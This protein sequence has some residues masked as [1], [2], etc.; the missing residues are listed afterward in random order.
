MN[1][2]ALRKAIIDAIIQTER[3]AINGRRM[4]IQEVIDKVDNIM[5]IAEDN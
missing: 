3:E 5:Q 2:P 4:P 1:T